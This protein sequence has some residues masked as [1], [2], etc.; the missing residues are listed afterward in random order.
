MGSFHLAL[1]A[2][3]NKVTGFLKGF[4]PRFSISLHKPSRLERR[5][6]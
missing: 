3:P 1:V 6:P 2:D 5:D 4:A